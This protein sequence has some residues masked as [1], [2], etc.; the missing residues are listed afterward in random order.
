[1]PGPLATPAPIPR[2][3]A[4]GRP[5]ADPACAGCAQLGA[6]RALRRAGLGVGGGSGCDAGGDPP[7]LAP[8]GPWAA[9]VGARRVLRGAVRVLAEAAAARVLVLA[10]RDGVAARRAAELL[11]RAG[12]RVVALDGADLAGAEA[13]VRDAAAEG[14][15]ALV[16]LSACARRSPRASPLSIAAARCNRCGA[17]LSLACPAISDAGGEAMVV[18]PAVCTGCGRCAPLCRGRAIARWP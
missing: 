17:C 7:L 3:V 6:F 16:A 8:G 1:V 5:A 9:V 10:D 4:T 18:D 11:E 2:A 13:T 15:I 14:G 12:T